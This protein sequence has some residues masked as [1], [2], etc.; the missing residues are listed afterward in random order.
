L[1]R[2]DVEVSMNNER[3]KRENGEESK[4]NEKGN[5]YK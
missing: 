3:K 2:R 1:R 5:F 4:E